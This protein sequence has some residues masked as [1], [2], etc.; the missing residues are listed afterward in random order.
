MKAASCAKSHEMSYTLEE[1]LYFDIGNKY[2]GDYIILITRNKESYKHYALKLCSS[3]LHYVTT[4]RPEVF[5][6][7]TIIALLSIVITFQ[8]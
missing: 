5:Q 4:V 2:R 6:T 8:L 1:K 7:G 3:N